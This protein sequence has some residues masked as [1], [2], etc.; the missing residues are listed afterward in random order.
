MPT[1]FTFNCPIL[2]KYISFILN[3]AQENPE[4]GSWVELPS[5]VIDLAKKAGIIHLPKY[6]WNLKKA[7]I[8][9]SNTPNSLSPDLNEAVDEE[10]QPDQVFIDEHGNKVD[11]PLSYACAPLNF[12]TGGYDPRVVLIWV[13]WLTFYA[14]L[15]TVDTLLGAPISTSLIIGP[16]LNW[17]LK[18]DEIL[19]ITILRY[20]PGRIL[21]ATGGRHPAKAKNDSGD[22]VSATWNLLS[23][24][25]GSAYW[26][27]AQMNFWFFAFA[28]RGSPLDVYKKEALL[29]LMGAYSLFLLSVFRIPGV[30]IFLCSRGVKTDIE[31]YF[32]K[33]KNAVAR[34]LAFRK[35]WLDHMDQF[36]SLSTETLL[37]CCHPECILNLL[38]KIKWANG[39]EAMCS[40]HDQ[41]YTMILVFMG[42]GAICKVGSDIY[43]QD[44]DSPGFQALLKACADALNRGRGIRAQNIKDQRRVV[45]ELVIVSTE[46]TNSSELKT[47]VDNAVNTFQFSSSGIRRK[48]DVQMTVLSQTLSK[49]PELD[50]KIVDLLCEKLNLDKAEV[51]QKKADAISARAASQLEN[52]R[53]LQRF[54]DGDETLTPTDRDKVAKIRRK[55]ASE[56]ARYASDSILLQRDDNKDTTLTQV[57][58]ERIIEV[59]RQRTANAVSEAARRAQEKKEQDTVREA[60]LRA[61]K[62]QRA[63]DKWRE[64][65]VSWGFKR[66]DIVVRPESLGLV[67]TRGE[68][69]TLRVGSI[70]P[71][72]QLKEKVAVNDVI[73]RM[74][75][76]YVINTEPKEIPKV[77]P[78]NIKT[79]EV[80]SKLV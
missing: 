66:H 26:K 1:N 46:P 53:L 9:S 12:L 79:L 52:D 2:I 78:K 75:D 13:L 16:V 10:A 70:K 48:K 29:V 76:V 44:K 14:F 65:L 74:D 59:R 72:S 22:L 67:L 68:H 33:G 71:N 56:A 54:D 41:G 42:V 47:A 25:L 7:I 55:R 40:M 5:N 63:V 20:C 38:I 50:S 23:L 11:N 24:S 34:A 32:F 61:K 39:L 27:C 77:M 17:D 49:Y 43:E 58:R 45:E 51:L 18:A 57:E 62:F 37:T 4:S 8:P 80:W 64:C 30:K 31:K 3:S 21:E 60:R 36:F 19:V 73:F 28:Y 35:F 6:L 15:I 69:K